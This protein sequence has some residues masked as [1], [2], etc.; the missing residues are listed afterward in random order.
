MITVWKFYCPRTTFILSVGVAVVIL[1]PTRYRSLP[2]CILN[3]NP[4]IKNE[5]YG[6][7]KV[8]IKGLW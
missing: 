4:V 6:V 2:S 5:K 8:S 1:L 7:K 3:K